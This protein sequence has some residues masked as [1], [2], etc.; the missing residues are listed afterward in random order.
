[1]WFLRLPENFDAYSKYT[2]T[3]TS[4]VDERRLYY[5]SSLWISL[6]FIAD[7][8]WKYLV[9]AG[10]TC[11]YCH[12]CNVELVIMR[13]EDDGESTWRVLSMLVAG[14]DGGSG[15]ADAKFKSVYFSR[16][17]INRIRSP[18]I[19]RQ[20]KSSTNGSLISPLIANSTWFQKRV[21]QIEIRFL[22]LECRIGKKTSSLA[23]LLLRDRFS[24]SLNPQ[25]SEKNFLRACFN[26]PI[27]S[28]V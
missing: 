9:I 11:A 25:H 26:L 12:V 18:P 23:L 13:L 24:L 20:Y 4:V 2:C 6:G 7:E 5:S 3:S 8:I 16:A 14:D 10:R 19:L 28:C 21:S 15:G 1:M 22:R 27:N 17:N